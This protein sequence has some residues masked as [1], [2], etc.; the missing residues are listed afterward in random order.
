MLTHLQIRD[1]AIIDSVELEFGPGLTVL[2]GETGAGKSILVDALLLV[3]GAR[4]SVEQIREGAERADISAS[5]DL[6]NAPR[7]LKDI[8]EAQSITSEDELVARRLITR[9]GRSRSYLNGQT[10]PLQVL[11][12]VTEQLLDVHGQHEFQSLVRGATQREILDQ[13]GQ[14]VSLCAEV[15]TS[16]RVWSALLNRQLEIESGLRDRDQRLG[17]LRFQL[18]EL[19]A[20]K[21]APQELE[22]LQAEATRLTH[23]S[24]LLEAT[25]LSLALLD[26]AEGQSAHALLSR[27]LNALR[28]LQDIDTRFQSMVS[29]LEQAS[30]SAKEAVHELS[31]YADSV[32]LDPARLHWVEKRLA[33]IEELSRKH[34]LPASELDARRQ[35]LESELAQLESAESDLQTLHRHL[36][37]ALKTY[38]DAAARLSAARA[39]ASRALSRDIT[40]GMQKLGMTG[41][42]FQIDVSPHADPQPRSHGVDQVEFRVTA[43]PGQPL[44][45]LQKVASG[46]ELSRLSLAVQVACLAAAQRSM[47]FD[48]VD[49]GIGGA[50]AEIVGQSLRKLGEQNQ[51]FCVTHLPQVASQGHQHFRVAKTTDGRHTRTVVTALSID[52]RIQEIARMLGGVQISERALAHAREMLESPAASVKPSGAKGTARAGSGRK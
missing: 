11:R 42:R 16:H 12:D 19:T 46:G 9:D 32:D 40:S 35:S 17:L 27:A 34:R 18:S 2:T 37:D 4:A 48:E 8:L 13:F 50:T 52:S 28:P 7:S 1:L 30:I 10:V 6:Q 49:S 23:G 44:R 20:L 43:N 45:S 29:L 38:Q 36:A 22:S 25:Q 33:S 41:G 31:R 47:I 5:F 15:E 39:A 14:H 24:R 26:G 51:V 3:C 21:L